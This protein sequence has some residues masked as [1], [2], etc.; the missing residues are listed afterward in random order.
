LPLFQK[1]NKWEKMSKNKVIAFT[2]LPIFGHFLKNEISEKK[3]QKLR[4]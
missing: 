3:E 2:F 1:V 4:L